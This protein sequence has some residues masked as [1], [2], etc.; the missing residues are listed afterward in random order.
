MR[1]TGFRPGSFPGLTLALLALAAAG[2]AWS[3]E[4][5]PRAKPEDV[6]VSSERL[7]RI[8]EAVKRHIDGRRIAG[9]VTLVA[10]KGRVVHFEAHG[11]AD[12]ETKKPMAREALFR[13][14]SST[15]PVTGV[16]VLMLVEEGKVRLTDPVSR[17]VPEFKNQMV[18]VEKGGKVEL[19]R[20]ERP[21]TIRDLMTHTSG[22]GSG[23]VGTRQ[24]A[25]ATVRPSGDDTLESYVA[26]MAKVPLDFQPGS[27]WRYSGLAGIDALSRVVEVASGL[28]YDEFLRKRIFNPLGMT[29]TSFHPGPGVPA[30]RLAAVHRPAGDRLEK[31]APFFSFPKTYHSGAGGLISKAEDYFRFGQMLANGGELNGKRLLSPR[32]VGLLSSNHVGEMFGGQLGRPKGM[33]FGLTVEVVTDPVRAGTFRSEGSYGW[34]GAF[35]THFWVDSKAKLVAVILMQAPAGPVAG[36]VQRDFE[37]AVMQALVE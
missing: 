29:N 37:T 14:A 19:V 15:K 34:D 18:A 16:A 32:A 22:L 28:P 9:A 8:G 24:V 1:L 5:L 35:G 6:G 13:M 10:R 36:G 33:G 12:V 26:R 4:E 23:G 21:V 27:Q 7:G 25:P 11:L 17:F 30:D 20:P 3:R 31:V 2:P